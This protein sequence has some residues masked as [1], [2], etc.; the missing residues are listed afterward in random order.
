MKTNKQTRSYKVCKNSSKFA[1]GAL[2]NVSLYG[3]VTDDIRSLDMCILTK[4]LLK[5]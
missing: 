3:S 2:K 4:Y 1:F 5:E